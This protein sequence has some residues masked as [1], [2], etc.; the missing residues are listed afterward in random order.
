[1]SRIFLMVFVLAIDSKS[2]AQSEL[3]VDPDMA[4]A[5]PISA[6]GV[7]ST[8]KAVEGSSVEKTTLAGVPALIRVPELV[9]Q[10]PVV[11]WHGLGPPGNKEALMAALPLDDLQAVKVYLDLPLFGERL[12]SGGLSELSARQARDYG[13]EIFAPV[14]LGAAG[15]LPSVV[16]AL[17]DRLGASQNEGVSLFGFSAGGAA[18]LL[19]LAERDVRIRKAV[20]LN[21]PNGLHGGVN[22]FETI[23]GATYSWSDEALAVG[24]RTDAIGRANEIGGSQHKPDLLLLHGLGDRM[25]P[26]ESTVAIEQ[27]L[28]AHYASADASNQLKLDLIAG[29]EH[30]WADGESVVLEA[31]QQRISA[32]FRGG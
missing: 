5:E 9:E 1:M 8:T 16:E 13:L 31:L 6:D 23:T 25:I 3:D 2:A 29:L 26:P 20:V 12:P 21:A 17:Q 15:E 27:A 24:S 28:R 4:T 11:L 7:S 10:P 22:A 32:W 18:V 30:H 19:T 14:V